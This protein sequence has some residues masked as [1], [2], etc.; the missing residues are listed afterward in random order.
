MSACSSYLIKNL[1]N[2]SLAKLLFPSIITFIFLIIFNSKIY[3]QPYMFDVEWNSNNDPVELIKI[4]LNSKS[5]YSFVNVTESFYQHYEVPSNDWIVTINKFCEETVLYNINNPKKYIKIHS[6]LGCFGGG[7]LFSKILNKIYYFEGIFRDQEQLTSINIKTK[8]NDS[9]LVIPYSY[10]QPLGNLEAFLSADEKILYFNVADT[11]YPPSINDKD[12]VYYFSTSKNEIIKKKRLYEFGYP[13]ADGYLLHR[14]RQGKAIVQSFYNNKTKDSYY[15]L[16]DFDNNVGSNFIFYQGYTTPYYTGNGNLLFLAETIDSAYDE[17][18][19]GKIFVYDLKT[20][21]LTKTLNLLPRGEI[22]TFD[23]YPNDIYY[24][25][26][27]Y[28]DF[29]KIFKISMTPMTQEIS[30]IQTNK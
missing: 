19:T 8:K 11:N 23:N 2:L 21:K 10:N 17:L 7:F 1:Y 24:I 16:Y 29:R 6:E 30:V 5:A 28:Y 9:L 12:F 25:I 27:F 13:K 4:D 3:T 18:N 26:D 22:Y 15:R 20:S 14:G